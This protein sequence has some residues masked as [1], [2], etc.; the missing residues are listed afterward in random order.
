V[1]GREGARGREGLLAPLG[2]EERGEGGRRRKRMMGSCSRCEGD[3]SNTL[4][5]AE[6]R[7]VQVK[8]GTIANVYPQLVVKGTG[9]NLLLG[10]LE[11]DIRLQQHLAKRFQVSLME[12]IIRYCPL[13]TFLTLDVHPELWKRTLNSGHAP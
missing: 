7:K 2:R 5:H 4:L 1:R 10:G 12:L 3:H 6:Y 13:A 8:E 9:Y 11:M